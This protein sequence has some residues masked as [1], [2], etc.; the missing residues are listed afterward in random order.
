MIPPHFFWDSIRFGL[1]SQIGKF[2]DRVCCAMV[3]EQLT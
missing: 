3:D 2:L 1:F